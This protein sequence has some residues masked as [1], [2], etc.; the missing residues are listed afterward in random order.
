M[1]VEVANA[2]KPL[3]PAPT[4]SRL[5]PGQLALYEDERGARI[6]GVASYV[7]KDT[8]RLVV[9][10]TI[11]IPKDDPL[12]AFDLPPGAK[13]RPLGTFAMLKGKF[14]KEWE[15]LASVVR[16][17]NTGGKALLVA[18]SL[19]I[20]ALRGRLGL[21]VSKDEAA[22]AMQKAQEMSD[23][24]REARTRKIRETIR[25]L[26]A[27]KDSYAGVAENTAAGSK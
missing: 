15:A 24:I 8:E 27:A 13:I 2:G 21:K 18:R 19:W 20:L 11:E 23:D 16:E 22:V 1:P 5:V 6:V 4:A 17:L 25:L 9:I 10:D 26:V 3:T 14:P 7:W 12:G